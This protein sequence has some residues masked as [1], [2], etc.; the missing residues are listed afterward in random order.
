[1][2]ESQAQENL[3]LIKKA[4][5]PESEEQANY[6]DNQIAEALGKMSLEK[7]LHVAAD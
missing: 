2:T 7:R 6:R 1:M 4:N 5:E 3:P